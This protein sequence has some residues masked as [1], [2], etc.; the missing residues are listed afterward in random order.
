M[1][2][3]N[4]IEQVCSMT[5]LDRI[6]CGCI[7]IIAFFFYEIGVLVYMQSV[8]YT[9]GECEKDHP[10]KYWWLLVNIIVYFFFFFI[11]IYFNCKTLCASVSREEVEKEMREEDKQHKD[12]HE[13][14]K[15]NTMHWRKVISC[16]DYEQSS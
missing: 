1:H 11:T 12:H 7:C 14:T 3:T 6:C 13:T 4:I 16:Y 5:G 9:S 10:M 15:G 8:F 2:A